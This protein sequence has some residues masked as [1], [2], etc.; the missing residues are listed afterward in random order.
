MTNTMAIDQ[1]GKTYHDLGKHPRKE[2]L[3]KL[4]YSK[5]EKMYQ[6]KKDG[7]TVHTGYIIGGLWLSLYEVRPIEVIQ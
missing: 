6:D 2:L 7:A 4:G 1:Y 3:N 5:A